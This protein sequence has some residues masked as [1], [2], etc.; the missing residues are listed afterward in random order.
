MQQRKNYYSKNFRRPK[1]SKLYLNLDRSGIRL[2]TWVN[3]SQN[4]HGERDGTRYEERVA[5]PFITLREMFRAHKCF[6]R[7]FLQH[8]TLSLNLSSNRNISTKRWMNIWQNYVH[9]NFFCLKYRWNLHHRKWWNYEIR[10]LKADQNR[11]LG[12]SPPILPHYKLVA[13]PL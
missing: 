2:Y 7:T 13:G 8:R 1:R 12:V 4:C 9:G 6:Q 5:N 10:S 11:Y 3:E